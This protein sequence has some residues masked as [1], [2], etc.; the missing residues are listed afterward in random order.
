M[1]RAPGLRFIVGC[2]A[3]L[4]GTSA[5]AVSAPSEAA[6][7]AAF[8]PRFARY[9]TWPPTVRPGTSAPIVL[10]TV[11][12]DPFGPLLEQSVSSQGV[13]GH[14]IVVRRLSS[15]A[16]VRG[17][18]VAFV[19]GSADQPTGQLLAAIGRQPVLTVTDTR[20]GSQRGIIHF[21]IRSGRVRFFI[22]EA[23]AAQRG[24]SSSSRLLNLAVAVRTR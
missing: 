22:D 6:V 5:Q 1:P 8:L 9:V 7:K 11:G 16:S 10:C 13:G 18:H 19:G 2:V 15:A 20:A 3:A 23:A 12:Q 4:A 24:L 17:C 14:S 21:A